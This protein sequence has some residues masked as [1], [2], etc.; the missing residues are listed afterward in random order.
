MYGASQERRRAACARGNATLLASTRLSASSGVL[1]NCQWSQSAA[2]PA[3]LT[4]TSPSHPTV[5]SGPCPTCA[6]SAYPAISLTSIRLPRRRWPKKACRAGLS[7]GLLGEARGWKPGAGVVELPGGKIDTLLDG[8]ERSATSSRRSSL[9]ASSPEAPRADQSIILLLGDRDE[10]RGERGNT[11]ARCVPFRRVQSSPLQPR[12]GPEANVAGIPRRQSRPA[13]RIAR[14]ANVNSRSLKACLEPMRI[15]EKDSRPEMVC[16]PAPG[17]D[18]L[19]GLSPSF[20]N[21]GS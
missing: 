20:G 15:D 8:F 4:A 9:T 12:G 6:G 5:L 16:D 13:L 2:R 14:R 17:D 10:S 18:C 3:G 21:E 11:F 19:A 1:R 7:N